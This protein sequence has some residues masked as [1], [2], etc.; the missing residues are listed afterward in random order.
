M[1]IVPEK[2]LKHL[3]NTNGLWEIKISVGNEI[4]RI[5]CFFDDGNLIILLTGFQKKTQKTPKN[6]INRAEKL[7]TEYYENK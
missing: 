4:F 7:K 5:F 3:T 6:E 1:N 2:Y